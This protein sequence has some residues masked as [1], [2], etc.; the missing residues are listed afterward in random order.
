MSDS[1][2]A[3]ALGVSEATAKRDLRSARAW[4]ATMLVDQP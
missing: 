2:L 1:E 3:A 4:L